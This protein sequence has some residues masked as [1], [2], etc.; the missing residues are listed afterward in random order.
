[1]VRCFGSTI[2][3]GETES[4]V[5]D[6]GV[7]G[8]EHRRFVAVSCDEREIWYSKE[9]TVSVG[10]V[11]I[12]WLWTWLGGGRE[13][14]RRRDSFERVQRDAMLHVTG[15]AN[16]QKGFEQV[17]LDVTE[18]EVGC[19]GKVE[20]RDGSK[21]RRSREQSD[22]VVKGKYGVDWGMEKHHCVNIMAVEV[23]IGWLWTWPG[24]GRESGRSRDGSERVQRDAML[25]V[26]GVANNQKGF[27]LVTLDVTEVEVGCPGKVENRDGSKT[28][29]SRE[30]GA[31]LVPEMARD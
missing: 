15:V 16:N 12:V 30:E 22:M 9:N 13:S 29:R 4:T 7:T 31:Q 18:V 26:T 6:D 10:E 8:D 14:E 1:M 19:P 27:E 2:I 28:R 5:R 11:Q 21:R 3:V 20:N 17:T 24:G 23:Q 25:H